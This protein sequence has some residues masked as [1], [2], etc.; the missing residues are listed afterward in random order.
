MSLSKTS[1]FAKN[2]VNFLKFLHF[3]DNV[4]FHTLKSYSCDLNQLLSLASPEKITVLPQ[5]SLTD[6]QIICSKDTCPSFHQTKYKQPLQDTAQ[7][8][9]LIQQTQRLWSELAPASRN[10]KA[11]CLKSFFKW[12]YKENQI[13]SDLSDKIHA[14]KVP[15]KIP[16][17][18]SVDEVL[19]LIDTLKKSNE[20]KEPHLNRD[21]T[22]IL[23]LYGGGLR[24]SE[25]C[26]LR[27]TDVRINQSTLLI[28]GKGGKER[29]VTPVKACFTQ[30]KKMDQGA[31]YVFGA[32]PLS[33]RI[34]YGIVR[35]WGEKAQIL[36]PISPHALRHSFATHLL[37]S[38][39]NLRA[40]Q[41]L[42]GH[43]SLSATEKYTHITTDQLQQTLNKHHPIE[44]R[45]KPSK[46]Q[47]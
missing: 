5:N 21:L 32:K 47:S 26:H 19:S 24:V 29:I 43:T 38:G 40:L 10:R 33:T 46:E 42:L 39:A 34:A 20:Q 30:L 22:L 44:R 14:P 11:A 15:K 25:A 2:M 27:W 16:Q 6:L 8:L 12:L 41:E 36:K 9:D 18:L 28:K 7:M 13:K 35:K 1:D 45:N 17:F 3:V 37:T 31:P 23:L 4:S